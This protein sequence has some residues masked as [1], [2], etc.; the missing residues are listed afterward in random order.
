VK[1]LCIDGGGIRGLIP[2]LVLA[3]VEQRTGR[4]IAEMI[5]LVAGT[6]TGGILACGLSRPGPDGRPMYSAEELA[7][8]YVEEGPR[9]FHR[10]L[11]KRI[12]SVEGW[13]DERYE[14]AGLEAALARYLG[15]DT[16]SEALVDV[17]ATAYDISGR[18]AFF[19]RSARAR[20][21]PTYDFP[22]VQVARATSAAPSY[23][24]PALATDVVGARTYPLIDGGV[25]AVNPSMCAYADVAAAGRDGELALMLSLGTGEQ[26]RAYTY[27]QTRWW[28]QLEWARPVLDMV[29]DGVADTTEFV[30]GT[31][32]SDRYVRLQTELNIASDDL[33]DASERNL[34]ALRTEA[35][36]LIAASEAK[37]DRAC[38]ILA[39]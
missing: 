8:I 35:E 2:A 29:F 4:R 25:Y 32:M 17:L 21:D 27:E 37:L 19:F 23:F 28:G 26:T 18:F 34:A 7:G 30:A 22:L 36:Q 39:A 13:L 38:A 5:D 20:S 11:L 9:I 12:F 31:L 24:E 14:D 10:G 15:E 6:S 3:E 16:L 1:V 33:D